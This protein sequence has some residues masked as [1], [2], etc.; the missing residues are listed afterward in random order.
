MQI[1]DIYFEWRTQTGKAHFGYDGF[2]MPLESS[3][4]WD[5]MFLSRRKRVLLPMFIVLKAIAPSAIGASSFYLR[6]L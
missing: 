5:V 6:G 2:L 4:R 3:Y 1:L